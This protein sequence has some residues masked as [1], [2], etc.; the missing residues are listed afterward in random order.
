M[1][2]SLEAFRLRAGEGRWVEIAVRPAKA[3]AITVDGKSI[4]IARA[5]ELQKVVGPANRSDR[6]QP[7]PAIARQRS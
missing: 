1:G 7:R 2:R 6:F 5:N 4:S 3:C